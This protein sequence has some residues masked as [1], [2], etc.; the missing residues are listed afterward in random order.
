[1]RGIWGIW[2]GNWGVTLG[3]SWKRSVCSMVKILDFW[4]P[5]LLCLIE[6][7]AIFRG[8]VWGGVLRGVPY[9]E[10]RKFAHNNW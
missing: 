9:R 4:A 6:K 1:M 3:A 10:K 5:E 8:R 7:V 2:G